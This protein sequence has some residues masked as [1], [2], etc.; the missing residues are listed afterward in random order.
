MDMDEDTR[1]WMTDIFNPSSDKTN[2]EVTQQD[3]Q[4]KK[5]GIGKATRVA[6][7]KVFDSSNKKIAHQIWKD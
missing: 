7:M 1:H 5:I 4:V 2:E 6:D 3:F